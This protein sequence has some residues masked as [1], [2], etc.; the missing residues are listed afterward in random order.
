MRSH[1]GR[2]KQ[3]KCES[4]E[5]AIKHKTIF[6]PQAQPDTLTGKASFAVECRG[7][8][9]QALLD[10]QTGQLLMQAAHST[11][12]K[13]LTNSPPCEDRHLSQALNETHHDS[14]ATLASLGELSEAQLNKSPQMSGSGFTEPRS[15]LRV[16][17]TVGKGHLKLPAPRTLAK[18]RGK[19]MPLEEQAGKS[20]PGEA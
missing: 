16:E 7:L 18:S 20:A 11:E 9:N 4:E 1:T 10:K 3:D 14:T 2:L 5:G 19:P 17:I 12:R 8:N 15:L 13:L 6:P